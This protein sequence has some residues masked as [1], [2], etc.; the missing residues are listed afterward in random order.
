MPHNSQF[1]RL[2]ERSD[3]NE[4]R[5]TKKLVC[6]GYYWVLQGLTGFYWVLLGFILIFHGFTKFYWVLLGFT[7]F[8]RVWLGFNGFSWVLLGLYGHYWLLLSYWSVS[9]WIALGDNRISRSEWSSSSQNQKVTKVKKVTE[10]RHWLHGK[11]REKKSVVSLSA[12]ESSVAVSRHRRHRPW[13]STEL[14][15]KARIPRTGGAGGALLIKT[16]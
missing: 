1:P 13:L 12:D 8:Y 6:T 4:P 7:W 2:L 14:P 16:Q 3:F 9:R 11:R 10:P 15:Y 5:T